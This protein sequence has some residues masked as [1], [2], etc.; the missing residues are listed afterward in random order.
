M[1][2]GEFEQTKI[3]IALANCAVGHTI[4]Y[5]NS[6]PSTMPLAHQRAADPTVV[7]GTIVTAEEQTAGRGRRQRQWAA[8]S[9]QGLLTSLILKAPI[10]LPIQQIPM[11]AGIVA[12]EAIATCIPSLSDQVGLKWPNDLLL[13]QS[14]ANA[15]KVGGILVEG[16]F[17]GTA[18]QYLV[19]G[20]GINVLQTADQL[21]AAPVGAPP[22]TSLLHYLTTTGMPIVPDIP[23]RSDLLIALCQSWAHLLSTANTSDFILAHWRAH[24]WTLGQTVEIRDENGTPI[25]RGMAS[26]VTADGQLVVDGAHGERHRFAAGDVS[27]RQKI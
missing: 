6:V 27:V 11:L 10:P 20:M 17:Q 22:P 9:G 3:A 16:R 15:C 13:G 5:Y 12:C 1:Y 19:I 4:D 2:S 18:L 24:L 8:P 21:P 25:C 7:S 14:M 23:N 26:D